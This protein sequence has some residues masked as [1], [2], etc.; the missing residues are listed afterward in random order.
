MIGWAADKG[1]PG[2]PVPLNAVRDYLPI[3]VRENAA[4]NAPAGKKESILG[5]DPDIQLMDIGDVTAGPAPTH[6]KRGRELDRERNAPRRREQ[7][8]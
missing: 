1:M 8:T 2:E 3:N 4:P 5:E 6:W 7:K